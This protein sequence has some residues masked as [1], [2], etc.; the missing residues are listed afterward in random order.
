MNKVM[1][2]LSFVVRVRLFGGV[3]FRFG[4]GPYREKTKYRK[5]RTHSIHGMIAMDIQYE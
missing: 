4:L 3:D 2:A 5:G 1:L